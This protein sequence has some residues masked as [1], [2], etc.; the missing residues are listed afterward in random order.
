[1]RVRDVQVKRR[2]P[3]SLLKNFAICSS[4]AASLLAGA[5][6]GHASTCSHAPFLPAGAAPHSCTALAPLVRLRT[7]LDTARAHD[8]KKQQSISVKAMQAA[9]QVLACTTECHS[10]DFAAGVW[11]TVRMRSKA[12]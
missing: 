5:S 3:V 9:A 10:S 1:M 11:T 4:K 6:P 8:G 2:Q 7:V 12:S